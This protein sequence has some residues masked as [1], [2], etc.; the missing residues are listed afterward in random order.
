MKFS[1]VI[2]TYNRRNLLE[3]AIARSLEQTAPC[4]VVV[5]DDCSQD[6]TADY[7]S[8]LSA[9]LQA[10]GDR[11]LIY[12]RNTSNQGH[13]Q[14][15]NTAVKLASGDWIKTLDDDDYLALDCIDVMSAAIAL[16]PAAAICSC[17]AAQVNEQ[18][19]QLSLTRRVGS[20][21]LCYVPQADI[22]Y[23]MLLEQIPFGTPVQVAFRRE[24]FLR[25]GGWDSD[26][27]ANFDDIDSWIKIAQFGD[28]LFINRCLAYR[29]IWPGAYNHRFALATRLQTHVA[30]KRE[31][32]ALVAESYRPL[33][34]SLSD[35]E[36]YLRLH[37]SLVALNQGHWREALRFAS[38]A[39]LLPRAWL[40]LL[41]SKQP[42]QWSRIRKLPLDAPALPV[43]DASVSAN[44]ASTRSNRRASR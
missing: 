43:S 42:H 28:A 21:E 36:A 18:E 24:A 38:P 2:T 15:V 29:T 27:D 9:R 12:H 16:H 4:E 20:S 31:I 23:G 37:W 34:P 26:L 32:H 30:I 14:S 8:H 3:R 22:H 25:S 41:Q 35:I 6:D 13:S 19:Q 7:V 5:V 11:R 40:L 17:Q 1:I 33:L 10:S 44:S 39:A